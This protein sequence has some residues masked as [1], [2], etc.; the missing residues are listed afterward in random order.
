MS[1]VFMWTVATYF[2]APELFAEIFK[3]RIESIVV[4]SGAIFVLPL[5]LLL[6]FW[7]QFDLPVAIAKA[8]S[9]DNKDEGSDKS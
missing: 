9:R 4:V 6:R 8:L 5:L 2:I 1:F 3:G 7:T